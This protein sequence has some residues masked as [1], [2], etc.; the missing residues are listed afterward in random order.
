[1]RVGTSSTMLALI[2]VNDSDG[3]GLVE[4]LARN[5]CVHAL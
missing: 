2:V 3:N 4:P 1:M 5:R